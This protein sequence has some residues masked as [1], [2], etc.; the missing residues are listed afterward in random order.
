ME[1]CFSHLGV[2]NSGERLLPASSLLYKVKGQ[3]C[4]TGCDLT[5]KKSWDEPSTF[6]P[7]Y[8]QPW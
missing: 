5:C 4:I 1:S 8:F 3:A 6:E 7:Y 2:S